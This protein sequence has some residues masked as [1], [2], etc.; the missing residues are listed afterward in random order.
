L[1]ASAAYTIGFPVSMFP[2]KI[3]KINLPVCIH[4]VTKFTV[5][6]SETRTFTLEHRHVCVG[7][8]AFLHNYTQIHHQDNN[9]NII[10]IYLIL[11][12]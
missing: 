3:K 8:T 10:H 5:C 6:Y 7:Y 4:C 12:M 11:Y 2:V 1:T 9:I